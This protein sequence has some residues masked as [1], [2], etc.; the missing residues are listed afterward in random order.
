MGIDPLLMIRLQDIFGPVSLGADP[1]KYV[2][3]ENWS[4]NLTRMSEGTN[5]PVREASPPPGNPP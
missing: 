3:S 2:Q 5:P 4:S 1:E